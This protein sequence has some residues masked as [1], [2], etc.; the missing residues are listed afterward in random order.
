M[1]EYVEA[2]LLLLPPEAGGRSAHVEPRAGSYRPFVRAGQAT[3]RI[4]VIEGPPRLVPGDEARV[5]VEVEEDETFL[6]RGSELPL[7]E[8]GGREVGVL[9]VMRIWRGA[10]A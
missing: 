4:R 7:L 3:L 9:T 10:V 1:A 6:R 2:M 8:L 5:V